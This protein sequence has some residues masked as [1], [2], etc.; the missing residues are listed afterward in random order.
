M[1]P[2]RLSSRVCSRIT[3]CA[4]TEWLQKAGVLGARVQLG[5]SGVRAS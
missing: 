3:A 5:Q 2:S 1:Q 4:G